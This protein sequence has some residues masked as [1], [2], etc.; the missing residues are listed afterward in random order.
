M[1]RRPDLSLL[2]I[3]F[4]ADLLEGFPSLLRLQQPFLL[5]LLERAHASA[6]KF[7][8]L[9]AAQ[10]SVLQADLRVHTERQALFLPRVAVLPSPIGRNSPSVPGHLPIQP[11][12]GATKLP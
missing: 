4:P 1:I 9:V 7:P 3:P 10:A 6:K 2:A 12:N 5:T 8:G 11:R